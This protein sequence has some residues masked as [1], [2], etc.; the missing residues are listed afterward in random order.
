V[1]GDASPPDPT[2]TPPAADA[3]PIGRSHGGQGEGHDRG[4]VPGMAAV[5]FLT[6]G[7]AAYLWRYHPPGRQPLVTIALLASSA[8]LALLLGTLALSAGPRVGLA[9]IR[10]KM[11]FSASLGVLF[12]FGD[13]VLAAH[14]MFVSP[15]DVPLLIA[16]LLFALVTSL[17]LVL[18]LAGMIGRAVGVLTRAARRMEAGHLDTPVP[19]EGGDELAALAAEMERM[20]GR[21]AEERRLRLALEATRRTLEETR[22]DL[23]AGISH[24]LRTPLNALQAVASALA[25][26][27]VAE[28]P[29]TAAHYLRELDAQVDRLAALVDDLFMLARLEG[30]APDL[31]RAP[32]PTSDL[33][34]SLLERAS[35]LARPAG[36]RLDVRVAPGTPAALVDVR[37]VERVLDNLVQ[38][39]LRHTP[40][41]GTITVT[42]APHAET[43]ADIVVVVCD[44][45]EGIAPADLPLLFERY[46]HGSGP[47]RGMGLG[48]AIVKAVVL[49]HGGRVWAESPPPGAAR[50]ACI[51][52]TLPI[53]IGA[54]GEVATD[55]PSSY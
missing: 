27:L 36:V 23:V 3:S 6:A 10:R 50:G 11:A 16:L 52:L 29:A 42:A 37:Q 21:L 38:N 26:G 43:P 25:D 31:A 34:S 44:T 12:A 55:A 14:L 32:Y 13:A 1:T 53:A 46:Y 4:L 5:C 33:L 18:S 17:T 19:V 2:A 35:P 24:D 49:A 40:P 45:G 9:T 48:L 41:G 20:A 8:A 51:G 54:S 39:A 28:E 15:A 22:R 47:A 30:P 7:E